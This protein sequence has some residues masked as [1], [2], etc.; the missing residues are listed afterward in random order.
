LYT[1]E[2]ST[3]L[4]YRGLVGLSGIN[5]VAD[6]ADLLDRSIIMELA[7]LA[8]DQRREE[9][10]LWR[11]F[12]VARPQIFGGMLDALARAM[13]VEPG[14]R[15]RSQPRMADFARWGAAAAVGL[16][17]SPKEFLD[18]YMCNVGRQNEAAVGASPVAQA[19]LALMERQESW[20]GSPA[21]LYDC[22]AE[23]A[24][25]ASIDTR[26]KRWPK[27]ASWLSR[28]LKEVQPNLLALGVKVQVEAGRTAGS[29]EIT[30][31]AMTSMT[32]SHGD[33]VIGNPV[34]KNALRCHDGND[35]ISATL[36]GSDLLSSH[37]S[38]S[39]GSCAVQ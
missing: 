27:S 29:R 16:R 23:I 6:R 19:V 39:Q 1:D 13:Q 14:I 37:V 20:T 11:E 25:T 24:E 5:L 8:P 9:R 30:M 22:L 36:E 2:D 26:S 3:V 10:E 32:T 28:R 33:A 15:L 21:D 18:A 12:E 38:A 35:S 17:R 4:E 31:T 34:H 7:P